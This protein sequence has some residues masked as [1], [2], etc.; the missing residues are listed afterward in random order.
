MNPRLLLLLSLLG[1]SASAVNDACD[2]WGSPL[3]NTAASDA[4]MV[5]VGSRFNSAGTSVAFIG[6]FNGD[7]HEDIAVGVP[8]NSANGRRAGAVDLYLSNHEAARVDGSPDCR[9]FGGAPYESAGWAVSAAGDVNADGYDDVIVGSKASG[10]SVNDEGVAWI[11]HGG[12]NLPVMVN[13]GT[14][15]AAELHGARTGDQFGMS[16][17]GVGDVNGDGFG[18]VAVGAPGADPTGVDAGAV[19]VFYGPVLGALAASQADVVRMGEGAG[20]RAGAAVAALGDV[21]GDDLPDIGV[22]APEWGPGL[23]EDG[24]VYVL[25]GA[26]LRPGLS[27]LAGADL[28]LRGATRERFGAS[29]ATAGDTNDDG[30]MDLWVGAPRGLLAQRGAVYLFQGS[31]AFVGEVE[32]ASVWQARVRGA[33][34]HDLFGAAVAGGADLDADGSTDLLAGAPS[35]DGEMLGSGAAWVVLGP[36]DGDV[37]VSTA[38]GWYG[39]PMY[40]ARTGSAVAMSVDASCDGFGDWMIGSPGVGIGA[41]AEGGA[42]SVFYGGHDVDDLRPW[43][44]DAD[45]DGWGSDLLTTTACVPPPGYVSRGGDCNDASAAFHPFAVELNCLDAAD[46]S[47]DGSVLGDDRDADGFAACLGDCDDGD[48]EVHP[49]QDERCGDEADNDCDQRIDDASAVDATDWRPDSDLDGY[50]NGD[51]VFRGCTPPTF[52]LQEP[53]TVGGDCDDYEPAVHP[54]V[55][56]RCDGVDADCDG[57][58]DEDA[59][60]ALDWFV[61]ADRDGAGDFASHERSCTPPTNGVLNADDCNDALSYLRPG[62][63]EVCNQRDDDCDGLWYRGGRVPASDAS[64]TVRGD[65]ADLRFGA[66][67]TTVPDADGDGDNELAVVATLLSGGAVVQVGRMDPVQGEY[68]WSTDLGSDLR[69]WSLRVSDDARS[70]EFGAALVGADFDGD[71][72]GDLAIGAPGAEHD[73]ALATGKVV[74][75]FGPFDGRDVTPDEADGVIYGAFGGDRAGQTLAAA[76][77]DHDGRAELLVAAPGFDAGFV[78][79]ETVEGPHQGG[80]GALFIVPGPRDR[81]SW[82][83]NLLD[84]E[85]RM[86][87]L[88]EGDRLGSALAV[89]G[90]T[91]GD[92]RVEVVVSSREGGARDEGYALVLD[93]PV[94]LSILGMYPSAVITATRPFGHA[95]TSLAAGDFSGDG[96]GDIAI[97]DGR[98]RVWIVPGT[99]NNW[100]SGSLE[101][102]AMARIDGRTNQDFGFAL[103]AADLNV[104]GVSDLVVGAPGDDEGGE[105]AGAVYIVYGSP[106]LSAVVAAEDLETFGRLAAGREGGTIS[107]TNSCSSEGAKLLGPGPGAELGQS[108]AAG[109]ATRVSA[110][111]GV[112]AGAPAAASRAGTVIAWHTGKYGLDVADPETRQFAESEVGWWPDVDGDGAPDRGAAMQFSCGMHVPNGRCDADDG[113]DGGPGS[114]GGDTDHGDEEDDSDEDVDT[115]AVGDTDAG[116]TDVAVDTDVVDTDA[117]TVTETGAEATDSGTSWTDSG[118]SDPGLVLE[119]GAP[120]DTGLDTDAG[121]GA[122]TD[123]DTDTAD[124][125]AAAI[126]PPGLE[127]EVSITTEDECRGREERTRIHVPLGTMVRMCFKVSNVGGVPLDH[128]HIGAENG[129]VVDDEVLEPGQFRRLISDPLPAMADTVLTAF[130]S[131]NADGAPVTAAPSNASLFVYRAELSMVMTVTTN[132]VCGDGDDA[133]LLSVR[134][135]AAVVRC[136]ELTNT[137]DVSITGVDIDDSGVR[138]D[139]SVPVGGTIVVAA[140]TVRPAS[141]TTWTVTATGRDGF[142]RP[143]RTEAVSAGVHVV[144]PALSLSATVAVDGVCPGLESVDAPSGQVLRW[145]YDV[146]NTGDTLLRDVTVDEGR[147]SVLIGELIPGERVLVGEDMEVARSVSREFVAAGTDTETLT[148]VVSDVDVASANVVTPSLRV[149]ATVSADG[150]CPGQ[151]SVAIPAGDLAT[152]CYEVLNDGDVPMVSVAMV[153]GGA[154]VDLGDLGVGDVVSWRA[155]SRPDDTTSRTAV[156][157]G[158]DALIGSPV[159]SMPDTATANVFHPELILEAT[160]SVDGRCPGASEVVS[161]QNR[162]VTFCY[163]VHNSGDTEIA[164]VYVRDGGLQLPVGTMASGQTTVVISSSRL[165]NDTT[166]GATARGVDVPTGTDVASLASRFSVDIVHPGLTLDVT[167]S[168]TDDCSGESSL[169]VVSG[170]LVYWC[171]ELSNTGDSDLNEVEADSDHG[172]FWSFPDLPEG[173]VTTLVFPQ[174]VTDDLTLAIEATSQDL[175]TLTPVNARSTSASVDVIHP[176]MEITATVSTTGACPG[177]LDAVVSYGDAFSWCYEVVNTGDVMLDDVVVFSG[178]VGDL[179]GLGTIEPGDAAMLVVPDFGEID[180][181]SVVQARGVDRPLGTWVESSEAMATVETVEPLV[182]VD[183]TVSL[184]GRCPG[185]DS[186][187]LGAGTRVTWCYLVTNAGDTRFQGGEVVDALGGMI[188]TLP[189]VLP[190]HTVSFSTSEV[191]NTT[192][193]HDVTVTVW[194]E[195]GVELRATDVITVD[196]TRPMPNVG[197]RMTAPRSVSLARSPSVVYQ[198]LVDNDGQVDA[199]ATVLELELPAALTLVSSTASQGTCSRSRLGVRCT[200]GA[201]PPGREVTVRVETMAAVALQLAETTARV[202][203]L[204]D[205]VSEQDDEDSARTWIASGASRTFDWWGVHPDMVEGCLDASGSSIDL[206][207]IRLR[208]ELRDNEIDAPQ[209]GDWDHDVE[210]GVEMVMGVLD[211]NL[212]RFVDGTPRHGVDKARIQA[213]RQII[214]AWCNSWYLGGT[215]DFDLTIAQRILAGTDPARMISLG[216]QAEAYN[217]TRSA[218]PLLA[219]PGLEDHA[220]PWDDP[221]DRND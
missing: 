78:E 213:G 56:E 108:V 148:R 26:S 31:D 47:C 217:R 219:D 71:G 179:G 105:R 58:I 74:V 9:L 125:A 92:R 103:D 55:A 17:A 115:D 70:S 18:D 90:D 136:Y 10:A 24:T 200:L 65:P 75:F 169:A 3:V 118:D 4:E 77:L 218:L 69:G 173:A 194:D 57:T 29:L 61:D 28:L 98:Q 197:V 198:V 162:V 66:R 123:T 128:L 91:N 94:P 193:T 109:F 143:V 161:R 190:Y 176:S 39:G 216:A 8:G 25:S 107:A 215:V 21:D 186:A 189:E 49:D 37:L 151:D 156:A 142:G 12:V 182:W 80:Q 203:T 220:Y 171:L 201:L 175:A 40:G 180:M 212:I 147:A 20:D 19:F 157:Y 152:W 181:T 99:G 184:D 207:F 209:G 1:A 132:G 141:D 133:A 51:V 59:L 102:A 89:I 60:D 44:R 68:D 127:V 206:G 158:V 174:V 106:E 22:G 119:T 84:T 168:L 146:T 42:V 72:H 178:A 43:H 52:F 177:V 149:E 130:G 79:D 100:V 124:T 64:W 35:A 199:P 34:S 7:G 97:G 166:H 32:A 210:T 11:V 221:T 96:V 38:E 165:Q 126:A 159:I 33:T 88:Q 145:C 101:D 62:R 183:V 111:G 45:R 195:F 85:P 150:N 93:V 2:G 121:G 41:R 112:V 13:L 14:D 138:R 137:G 6:D 187:E 95:G 30:R 36:F 16:V 129:V 134:E 104:D 73:A 63:I 15:A 81:E 154:A 188:G 196:V 117:G 170:T 114:G 50:G 202:S 153:E 48:A 185:I 122:D 46:Y 86:L 135:G 163:R 113:H 140:N 208:D 167:A 204:L 67:I 82:R 27:S 54:G 164:D 53:V 160:A 5:A 83:A 110:N 155:V 116:D 144:H 172:D 131:A 120:V 23:S 191:L 211:A 214:A 192:V 205:Q 139:V 87:G 76:D